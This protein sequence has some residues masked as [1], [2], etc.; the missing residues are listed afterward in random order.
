MEQPKEDKGNIFLWNGEI[1]GGIEVVYQC[2]F[3]KNFFFQFI[4]SFVNISLTMI[5]IILLGKLFYDAFQPQIKHHYLK[6]KLKL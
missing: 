3:S 5:T 6:K 1:F 4:Y 2:L